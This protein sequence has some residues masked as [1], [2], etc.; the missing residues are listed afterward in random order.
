MPQV[1]F[2]GGVAG[3]TTIAMAHAWRYAASDVEAVRHSVEAQ[4]NASAQNVDVPALPISR[5]GCVALNVAFKQNVILSAARAGYPSGYTTSSTLGS[6]AGIS[7]LFNATPAV[8]GEPAGT[9]TVTGGA[10]ALS[11]SIA[12]SILPYVTTWTSIS[13]ADD[14]CDFVEEFNRVSNATCEALAELEQAVIE[15]K[16]IPAARVSATPGVTALLLGLVPYST[17]DFD[18]TGMVDLVSDPD[19]INMLP[20]GIWMNGHAAHSSHFAPGGGIVDIGGYPTILNGVSVIDLIPVNNPP[21]G[22]GAGASGNLEVVPPEGERVSTECY[23]LAFFDSPQ[24]IASSM[25]Y[26]F[27]VSD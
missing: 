16:N 17:V 19:G 6:D 25:L 9:I 4:T 23:N 7:M 3:D 2:V 10:A 18:P 27:K 20:G 14:P 5:D 1:D 13:S 11:W 22:G 26:A 24:T 21:G 12:I 15:L 8:G